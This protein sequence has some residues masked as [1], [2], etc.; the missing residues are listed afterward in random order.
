VRSA[1]MMRDVSRYRFL[2]IVPGEWNRIILG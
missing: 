1:A 2:M